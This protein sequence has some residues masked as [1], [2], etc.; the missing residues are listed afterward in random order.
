MKQLDESEFDN[1]T[2]S[3][4]LVRMQAVQADGDP[5]AQEHAFDPSAIESAAIASKLMEEHM[6]AYAKAQQH[7]A[8]ANSNDSQIGS[9]DD[10]DKDQAL[11]GKADQEHDL[12]NNSVEIGDQKLGLAKELGAPGL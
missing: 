11:A 7:Y 9:A 12:G 3:C 8:Q 10:P 5:L 4:K 1:M 6:E 2:H